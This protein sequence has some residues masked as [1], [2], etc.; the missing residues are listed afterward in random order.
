MSGY[1]VH[2]KIALF[3]F[4]FLFFILTTY[5]ET[6]SGNVREDNI[7]NKKS[8]IIDSET[9]K[10]VEGAKIYLPNYGFGTTTDNEGKFELNANISDKAI[11]QVEKEGYRPFSI[12]V[13]KSITERP[14][15][16][17]IEKI[18]ASDIFV[19]TGIYHLGDD[20]Y[21]SN[22]ANCR[23]FKAKPMG[24][25]YSKV[26]KMNKTD[27]TKQAVIIFGSVIGLDTKLAKELGQ[28]AIVSVYSSPV[29]IIFNGQKIGELNMNG[30]NQQ[31]IIPNRLIKGNNELT[32]KTGKNLFQYNYIDYDDME[33]ANLRI[34]I[35]D[36]V[37][38]NK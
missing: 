31:I 30:D 15:K 21:S 17:G 34:E 13:D 16:L 12:T 11:L 3:L 19:D 18:K 8:I 37:F 2:K 23:Q 24:P 14:L 4:I 22:S 33:F 35:R 10:A 25:F 36:K 29:E 28:N 7:L 32:V 1:N 6:I 27:N 26:I 20:V 38:A 9:E 5:A